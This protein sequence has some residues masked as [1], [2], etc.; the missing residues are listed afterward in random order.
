M[1]MA[2]WQNPGINEGLAQMVEQ[3]FCKPKEMSGKPPAISP[4][5]SSLLLGFGK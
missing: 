4:E 2:T 5:D 3:W 1:G